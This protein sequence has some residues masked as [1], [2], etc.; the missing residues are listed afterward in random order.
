MKKR[1]SRKWAM[2]ACRQGSS[3]DP[4]RL[5][6]ETATERVAGSGLM[7]TGMPLL[8]HSCTTP[9]SSSMEGGEA[10]PLNN[11]L[12][13]ATMMSGDVLAYAVRNLFR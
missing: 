7:I 6:T 3:R 11:G 1:C 12:A 13:G 2:P 8:V 5:V 10:L 9:P 4:N